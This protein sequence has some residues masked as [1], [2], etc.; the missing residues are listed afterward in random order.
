[1]ILGSKRM[2]SLNLLVI[3]SH[4]RLTPPAHYIS[5]KC[6]VQHCRLTPSAQL[7]LLNTVY[8]CRVGFGGMARRLQTQPHPYQYN[9]VRNP[10]V[11]FQA[12]KG[13]QTLIPRYGQELLDFVE[14]FT[15]DEHTVPKFYLLPKVHKTVIAGRPIVASFNWIN[16]YASRLLSIRLQLI[17][18]QLQQYRQDGLLSFMPIVSSSFEAKQL[19][20]AWCESNQQHWREHRLPKLVCTS[21]DFTSLYTNLQHNTIRNNITYIM[22]M[23]NGLNPHQWTEDEMLCIETLTAFV[24]NST[25]FHCPEL[26]ATYHQVVGLPIEWAPIVHL[27]L[28]T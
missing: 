24:I 2:K 13:I 23:M 21:W 25:Y 19:L 16:T 4:C 3:V 17:V 27:S 11:A 9:Q 28:P 12:L 7:T 6:S 26:Q 1:M 5:R 22:T 20:L 10:S 14:A 8:Y 18:A 15:I